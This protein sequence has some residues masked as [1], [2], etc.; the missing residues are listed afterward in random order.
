MPKTESRKEAL[1]KFGGLF[2]RRERPG[3]RAYRLHRAEEIH[4]LLV[5]YVT[6]R[7]DGEEII[8]GRGGNVSLRNGELLVFTAGDIVFRAD[9]A[10]VEIA[11][12]LS[13]DGVVIREDANGA[14]MPRTL[15]VYFVDYRK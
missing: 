6:E 14:E 4:G 8:L 5:R 1:L 2:G 15:V 12:L 9:A 13:G 10:T 11:D 3:S 7:R